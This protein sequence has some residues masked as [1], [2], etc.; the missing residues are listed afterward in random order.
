VDVSRVRFIP[1]ALAKLRSAPPVGE[2][3]QYEVK[4]DGFRI[5]IHKLG[6]AVAL[7]G[8]NGG[9]LT[10]RFPTIATALLALPVRSCIIDGEL[11][12]AGA[13]GQPDFMALLHGRHVP[14]CVYAFELLESQGRDLR[15][16][17]LEQRRAQLKRLLNRSKGNLIRF[18]DSFPDP[19]VLLAECIRLGLEG[20]VCKR[21]D[22]PYRSGGRS[23][24]IKVKTEQWKSAN[25]FRAQ[26]FE[27]ARA[28]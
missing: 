17:P 27:K 20:I 16:L 7:F 18:S 24:W 23:G 1:P 2:Q 3:W 21:K 6:L 10:T 14:V 25:R 28:R 22:A 12:A 15:E 9:N 13:E 19:I 11:I 26:L 8:K 5:Q 4:F